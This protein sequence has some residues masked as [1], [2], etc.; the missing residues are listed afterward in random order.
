MEGLHVCGTYVVTSD[1]C[2]AEISLSHL[3]SWSVTILLVLGYSGA[4]LRELGVTRE[5]LL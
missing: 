4:L 2:H 1:N 5:G 3:C